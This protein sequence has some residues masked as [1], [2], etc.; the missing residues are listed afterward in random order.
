V[1]WDE[2]FLDEIGVP[3]AEDEEKNCQRPSAAINAG[4]G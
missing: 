4:C 3:L 2:K 1:H